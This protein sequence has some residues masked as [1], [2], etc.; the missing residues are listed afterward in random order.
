MPR[1][2]EAT[3][4][5]QIAQSGRTAA[6]IL[7]DIAEAA[8]SSS[9]KG[10]AGVGSMIFE[11]VDVSHLIGSICSR[12]DICLQNVKSNKEKCLMM[13]EQ[14]YELVCAVI[15]CCEEAIELAPAFLH[16]ISTLTS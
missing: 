12:S 16:A 14:V 13:T 9:L 8:K 3:K 7:R 1:Q 2:R 6:G 11:M 15:N 10:L 5:E 4:S